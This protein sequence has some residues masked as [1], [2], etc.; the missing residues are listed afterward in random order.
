MYAIKWQNHHMKAVW[1]SYESLVNKKRGP[2][3]K[4]VLSALLFLSSFCYRVEQHR[5]L[6]SQ[7]K[8]S[9]YRAKSVLLSEKIVSQPVSLVILQ[10]ENIN[11]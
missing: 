3:S 2:D 6:C 5:V 10:A 9:F 1:M 8:G 7:V 4:N 11:Q